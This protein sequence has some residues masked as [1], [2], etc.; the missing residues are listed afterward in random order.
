LTA[1]SQQSATAAEEVT[2]TVEEIARGA[3]EQALSTEEGASKATSLGEAIEKNKGYINELNDSG[4]KIAVIVNEGLDGIN[5]LSKITEES[6]VATSE[7]QEVILKTNESSNKIG[8]ASNVILAIAEQTNLLALNAAIEAARA[9]DAGRGFAVVA[10]EIR[11]LAEQ[12]SAS[13][14]EIDN[15]VNELQNNAQ[16]AV[17]TMERVSLI[18]KEQTNSVMDN[19]NKYMVISEAIKGAVDATRKLYVSSKEMET[20]KNEI[21]NTLQNLT[22]IAEEN[23]ASTQEASAS[24]EEQSAAIEQI[25][26]ANEGLAKLAQN[27]QMIIS[28]FRV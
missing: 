17:K 12:S 13:T 16:N 28:R 19:K 7:I 2:K 5:M 4:E 6:T 11:K 8:Q 20:M 15:V 9:G 22:A 14:M 1:T 27:L 10:D 25:A 26:G 18:A 24:M 23:S 3:S 21:L